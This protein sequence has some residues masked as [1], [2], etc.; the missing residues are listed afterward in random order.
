MGLPRFVYPLRM[1]SAPQ[2]GFLR[3]GDLA[4]PNLLVSKSSTTGCDE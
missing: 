4:L 3:N 2:L 1:N